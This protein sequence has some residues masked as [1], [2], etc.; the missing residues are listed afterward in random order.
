MIRENPQQF[1]A[2]RFREGADVGQ[3]TGRHQRIP[4]RQI[5][6]LFQSDHVFRP[7]HVFTGQGGG[8][9]LRQ[10]QFAL[11]GVHFINGTLF[12]GLGRIKFNF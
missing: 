6:V 4:D 5:F 12:F 9:P 10:I 11:T 2:V 7:A 1:V 3:K 8:Q